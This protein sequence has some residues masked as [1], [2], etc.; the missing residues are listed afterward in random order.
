M[1][2][3][4][5]EKS[6]RRVSHSLYRTYL[7][8]RNGVLNF[9]IAVP[10]HLQS[11]LKKKEIRKSLNTAKLREARPMAMRLAVLAMQY[12]ELLEKIR[13]DVV[14]FGYKNSMQLADINGDFYDFTDTFWLEAASSKENVTELLKFYLNPLGGKKA[15]SAETVSVRKA[16]AYISACN[17]CL[18][19]ISS[20]SVE[21]KEENLGREHIRNYFEV[22]KNLPNR[23]NKNIYQNKSWHQLAEM[24]R[25]GMA[26]R[27]LGT[28]TL[29][30]RQINIRSFINW[31]EL[32]Y[33]GIIQ[34]RYI[35]SG[36]P[37]VVHDKRVLQKG[38]KRVGFTE[39]E[40]QR[41][42][43]DQARYFAASEGSE[44]RYW[45]PLIA[46]Y[47]GMRVEE[48]CQL[49]IGDIVQIDGI[50]CFS[51]N[52][53]TDNKG[54]F[55]HVKSLAGIRNIPVYPYLWESIGF[56]KFVENRRAQVSES[57]Y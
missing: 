54:H 6:S 30:G 55:K 19:P 41:L 49:Y 38:N 40:L 37:K 15:V 42:F 48:I 10:N 51:V 13:A 3:F 8:S 1:S 32:E 29:E 33:K 9:R 44:V 50:W 2:E 52:E 11:L 39:D 47:T 28:K 7:F 56:K 23:T 14:R 57:Q 46:L 35:N 20:Q 24:G 5:I 45:A 36:F 31:C 27:L 21:N 43:G 26:D 22:L 53:N 25:K 34:A 16:E 12:F 4:C 18:R 17:E